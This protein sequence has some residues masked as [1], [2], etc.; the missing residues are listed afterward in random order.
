MSPRPSQASLSRTLTSRP[1][2]RSR[3]SLKAARCP[4]AAHVENLGREGC[5]CVAYPPLAQDGSHTIC[6]YDWIGYWLVCCERCLPS[7]DYRAWGRAALVWC[8][9]VCAGHV[10]ST[11]A[12]PS[13]A[14]RLPLPTLSTL[15][16]ELALDPGERGAEPR[17]CVRVVCV[18]ERGSL[19][20]DM[21]TV[22]RQQSPE[23]HRWESERGE[24]PET[25]DK[26]E[27][28]VRT[29]LARFLI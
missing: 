1:T 14:Q 21:C 6:A 8:V 18:C 11:C 5:E 16:D 17:L 2:L 15:A 3:R 28:R 20:C 27:G 24:T 22:C 4:A 10:P 19:A 13:L 12:G 7:R 23:T 29:L 25:G 26:R 9:S